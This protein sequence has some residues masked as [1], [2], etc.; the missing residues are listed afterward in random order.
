M[1]MDDKAENKYTD[2]QIMKIAN[3]VAN[4][5]KAELGNRLRDVIL[6]GS[7]ARGEG[8]DWSDI[9]V[10]ILVQGDDLEASRIKKLL[11]DKLWSIIYETN[12]MLSIIVVSASRFDQYKAVLP[13]YSNVEKEGKRISA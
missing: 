9:D 3:E 6:Y 5:A 4:V 7:Y 2:G 13:F 1:R 11:T 8:V 12:L 10:M